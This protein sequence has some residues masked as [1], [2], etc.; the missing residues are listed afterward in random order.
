MLTGLLK[1]SMEDKYIVIV[2]SLQEVISTLNVDFL[3]GRIVAIEV[4]VELFLRHA[5]DLF[6]LA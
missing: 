4:L 2:T 3:K 5:F 1:E 6:I